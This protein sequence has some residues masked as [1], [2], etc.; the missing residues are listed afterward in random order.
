MFP[1]P[2]ADGSW[3]AT[4]AYDDSP[5]AVVLAVE[6]ASSSDLTWFRDD[7]LGVVWVDAVGVD[8]LPR[9]DEEDFLLSDFSDFLWAAE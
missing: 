5:V 1:A 7:F 3:A 4:E 8:F 2:S 6:G 9:D